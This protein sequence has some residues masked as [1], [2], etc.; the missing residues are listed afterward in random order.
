MQERRRPGRGV[1]GKGQ[2]RKSTHLEKLPPLRR[3]HLASMVAAVTGSDAA[4]LQANVGDVLA[5]GMA[6]VVETQP[7]DPVACLA[8]FLLSSHA[9]E[10]AAANAVRYA[11]DIGT[12]SSLK[13]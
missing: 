5:R 3:F 7:D 1:A 4:W 8:S 9:S 12:K 6:K 13:T 10:R 11:Q 2:H